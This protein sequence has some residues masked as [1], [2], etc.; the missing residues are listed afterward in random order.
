M[1]NNPTENWRW[2]A[3]GI[4]KLLRDSSLLGGWEELFGEGEK[5]RWSVSKPRMVTP[6]DAARVSAGGMSS[7]TC[8]WERICPQELPNNPKPAPCG[9]MLLKLLLTQA[10]EIKKAAVL[11]PRFP[12][13]V[14][15]FLSQWFLDLLLRPQL[16]KKKKLNKSWTGLQMLV[17]WLHSNT[18]SPGKQ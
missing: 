2:K 5:F 18:N 8:C 13:F 1:T 9:V 12:E 14:A 7:R 17:T 16:R 3:T 4:N 11:V 15:I 10:Q 6:A